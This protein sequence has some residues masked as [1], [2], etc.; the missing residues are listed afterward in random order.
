[1]RNIFSAVVFA[2]CLCLACPISA[3][4]PT[5][6]LERT[7]S[8]EF[9][10]PVIRYNELPDDLKAVD[11]NL[12]GLADM[13]ALYSPYAGVTA[14]LRGGSPDL[15]QRV[16]AYLSCYW[17][18]GKAIEWR[19]AEYI[20]AYR[21]D[22]PRPTLGYSGDSPA[23]ATNPL[24]L[25]TLRLRVLRADQIASMT[26]RPDLTKSGWL[27]VVDDAAR[28]KE[29]GGGSQAAAISNMKQ[30]A[31]A[32]LMYSNDYDDLFPNAHSASQAKSALMPYSKN[33]RLFKTQNPN[34]GQLLFNVNL[35]AIAAT[36]IAQP[37][38]MPLYYDS[39]PWPDG[40]RPVAFVDGHARYVPAGEWP[41]VA[42]ELARKFKRPPPPAPAKTGK[43]GKK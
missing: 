3:Q 37:T 31:L 7:L 6:P 23:V 17:T 33:D 5:G 41:L 39:L 9:G 8:G 21:A 20:V 24:S 27:A 36:A 30:V 29:G 12:G 16:S 2:L 11:L 18:T 43:K 1:M 22:V 14:G 15:I 26:P 34:G 19:G 42:A 40:G 13:E 25:Q 32:A 4:A 35:A 28:S 38:T 10:Q